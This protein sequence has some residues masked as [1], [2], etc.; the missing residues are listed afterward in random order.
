MHLRETL[1]AGGATISDTL[2]IV[3]TAIEVPLMIL[4]MAFGAACFGKQ[5]RD[6]SIAS[7]VCMVT[8]GVL[9]GT[10]SGNI[11]L[12]L[13]TPWIGVWERLSIGAFLL[14]TVVVATRLLRARRRRQSSSRRSATS[15]PRRPIRCTFTRSGA[16]E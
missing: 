11:D 6:Y 5:F 1:A 10:Q 16:I 2:H 12:N 8:F 9:T 7:I 4:A 13:P 14:W 15:S 3:W